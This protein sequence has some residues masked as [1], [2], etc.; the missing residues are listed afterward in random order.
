MLKC[1][2]VCIP[3]FQLHDLGQVTSSPEISVA[4]SIKRG[5]SQFLLGNTVMRVDEA[6]HFMCLTYHLTHSKDLMLIIIT[7]NFCKMVL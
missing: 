7:I 4:A 5:K 3:A 6:V 1:N 2:Q